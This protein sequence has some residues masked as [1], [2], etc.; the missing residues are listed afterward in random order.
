MENVMFTSTCKHILIQVVCA[1]V[2]LTRQFCILIHRQNRPL[3]FL[4]QNWWR[5]WRGGVLHFLWQNRWRWWQG[6]LLHFLWQNWWRFGKYIFPPSSSS[7]ATCPVNDDPSFYMFF[8]LSICTKLD[9]DHL[10]ACFV[11][12]NSM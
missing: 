11:L 4:W 6:G 3:H 1:C 8:L 7:F 5:W 10:P 9:I 12:I 2:C